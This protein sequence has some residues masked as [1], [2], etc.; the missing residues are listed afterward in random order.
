LVE[1]IDS[2]VADDTY[3][4]KSIGVI[5]LQGHAQAELIET[6]L[7]QRLDP[8]TIEER[9]LRC[10]EAATFQGDQR[11]VILLS[12]V[13]APNVHYRALTRLPDQRRF[14]VAMSRARD[15]VWLIH[16]VKQHD[17]GPDD[18]R[19][20]LVS[21]FDSP[22]QAAL[23]AL[24]EDIDQLERQARSSR[25]RGSQPEPY[26]SW[27]E[28]DVALELLRQKYRVRPQVE[29]AGKRIDLV[30][31]GL[32]SRL[33]VE[34]DGEEWH[35]A[36]EY[37][38]DMARQR[39]LERAG[40]T[41][42][43][44]R[45]SEFYADRK[46]ALRMMTAACEELGILPLDFVEDPPSETPRE[47]GVTEESGGRSSSR[48]ESSVQQDREEDDAETESPTAE[49]GPF[50]GYSESLGFPDPRD[51]SPAIVR[52]VLRRIVEKDGPLTRAS[53]CRLYVEGCP[54]LQRVGR[55][56]RQA[57]NRTL[58]AMLRA[59]EIVQEDELRDGSPEGQVLRAAGSAMVK[60]RPAGRRDLLE[61]PP[62][63]LLTVLRSL[64]GSTQ[65]MN[66][67]EERLLRALLEHYGFS[68]LTKPRREYL[69][70]VLRLRREQENGT[71]ARRTSDEAV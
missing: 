23:D 4:G 28:V 40:W 49:Y 59:G 43:R 8:K 6:L 5:A 48:G 41:F 33:A 21:F 39:Q 31:D 18:L 27:F 37:E 61:I 44:V 56:V 12:L 7:A 1:I 2:L 11:D 51:S 54:G 71:G 22:G 25:R 34:C 9:R 17:L 10:G 46:S 66:D 65:S 19:R 52:A 69:S 63:E 38:R 60:V 45:E 3:E 16:S 53:A 26:E 20:K 36:E 14:N 67:D 50:T 68:R 15:Q 24:F 70:K 32:D 55:V 29:V 35:G 64:R 62:S 42:A 58:G 13:I 47:T 57:L 30:V